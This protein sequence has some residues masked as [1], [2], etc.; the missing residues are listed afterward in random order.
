MVANYVWYSNTHVFPRD[1]LDVPMHLSTS[2]DNF[3]VPL[4]SLVTWLTFITMGGLAL[5]TV[6]RRFFELFYYSHHITYCLLIP[7]VLWHAAAGW[8]FLLPGV[9]LWFVDR[10]MRAYR[11]AASVTVISAAVHDVGHAG[12]I[13]S[14]RCR[15]PFAYKPGQYVFI[16]V[17]ELSLFQWHPFTIASTEL[18]I[19][20][21]HISQQGKKDTFTA[22]LASLVREGGRLTVSVDGPYGLPLDYH[23]YNQIVLMAGGIGITP[24]MAI[25]TALAAN[26]SMLRNLERVILVWTARDRLLIE[27]LHPALTSIARDSR[28][29]IRFHGWRGVVVTSFILFAL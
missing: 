16:N 25:Y 11:S 1:I 8:E 12:T 14:L 21:L 18:G 27:R 19:I 15:V 10:C 29:S 3:T 20:D 6:R 28:F 2:I 4:V 22:R 13:T 9:A 26:K 24:C 17:A 23:G 5:W 7:T